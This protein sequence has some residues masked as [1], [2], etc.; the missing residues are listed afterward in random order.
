MVILRR[1]SR[2]F[3]VMGMLADE[4]AG[5][6]MVM[7][8]LIGLGHQKIAHISGELFSRSGLKRFEGYRKALYEN[9]IPYRVEYVQ[10]SDQTTEKGSYDAMMRL[11]E[12][13][14]PPTAVFA[15]NDTVAFGAAECH[16]GQG[17]SHTG[18]YISGRT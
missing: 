16:T 14:D 13:E 7:E 18:R 6:S 8:H 15:F 1:S 12:L 17:S 11:L 5:V 10:E 4:L 2:E 3:G 9:G